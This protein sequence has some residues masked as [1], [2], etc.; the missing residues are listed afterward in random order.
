MTLSNWYLRSVPGKRISTVQKDTYFRHRMTGLS[1]AEAARK[2]G[3][4]KATGDGLERDKRNRMP[5]F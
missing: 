2:A 1:V 5:L 4:S 3:F